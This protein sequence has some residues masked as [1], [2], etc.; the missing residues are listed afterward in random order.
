[1]VAE[2][3][4]EW[5]VHARRADF[6]ITTTDGDRVGVRSLPLH[7][8][9]VSVLTGRGAVSFSSFGGEGELLAR[10]S[11][12]SYA[13]KVRRERAHLAITAG[14]EGGSQAHSVNVASAVTDPLRYFVL[15]AMLSCFSARL[16]CLSGL[17]VSPERAS[18]SKVWA[19]RSCS[20]HLGLVLTL[21]DGHLL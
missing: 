13:C 1:M 2:S 17:P 7:L 5:F 6:A 8:T 20:S 14:S 10:C 3:T 15:R 4:P 11:R 9:C 16:T 21:R 18:S 19:A 12:T